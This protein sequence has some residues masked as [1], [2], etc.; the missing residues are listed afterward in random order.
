[1]LPSFCEDGLDND[2]DGDTDLADSDCVV[3]GSGETPAAPKN[4]CADEIDNDGDG[5]T[6]L[7]DTAD[8]L[9]DG[10]GESYLP[11]CN[12]GEDN[13]DDGSI[14]L[15][16]SDCLGGEGEQV[17]PPLP[18]AL[19]NCA[20]EIDN[21]GDGLTDAEDTGD[22]AESG[23]GEYALDNC[24]DGLDQDDDGLTDLDDPDCQTSAGGTGEF[25]PPIDIPDEVA[26]TNAS[27]DS[28]ANNVPEDATP[29]EAAA[30]IEGTQAGD[31]IA[32]SEALTENEAN[33]AAVVEIQTALTDL[34]GDAGSGELTD[35]V[36]VTAFTNSITDSIAEYG[37]LPGA[38]VSESIDELLADVAEDSVLSELLAS[39]D[40]GGRGSGPPVS[41]PLL[42]K[43]FGTQG[44]EECVE[45]CNDDFATC[46][47]ACFSG[48]QAQYD[49]CTSTANTTHSECSADIAT[50]FTACNASAETARTSC[51]S[52]IN[53]EYDD[54]VVDMNA[55]ALSDSLACVAVIQSDYDGCLD[56]AGTAL[57]GC[58]A[59]VNSN[60]TDCDQSAFDQNAVNVNTAMVQF[61]AMMEMSTSLLANPA[62]AGYATFIQTVALCNFM[63]NLMVGIE[64]Y[65]ADLGYCSASE[66]IQNDD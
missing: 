31:V 22:C 35:P 20:D 64:I 16:D 14:D 48:V 26:Q 30:A 60:A 34:A 52:I 19:P 25:A 37:V 29:E 1:M 23:T 27:A 15:V 9:G 5:L 6:D 11:N 4:N 32:A 53:A 44:Y 2:L 63:N 59:T 61:N 7:D 36:T 21:D 43:T 12:D 57:T 46:N 56:D 45:E 42:Y 49:A 38:V 62:L 41:P 17:P 28:L 18:P 50:N 13:D 33:A 47:S 55:N 8:C 24:A 66:G 10:L 3:G 39:F 65:N 54:C 40:I 51:I 58:A